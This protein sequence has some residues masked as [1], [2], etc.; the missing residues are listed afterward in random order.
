MV[1]SVGTLMSEVGAG[2]TQ[3]EGIVSFEILARGVTS[4]NMNAYRLARGFKWSDAPSTTLLG[5]ESS[6]LTCEEDAAWNAEI[7]AMLAS[8]DDITVILTVDA[9]ESTVWTI[10]GAIKINADVGV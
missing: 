6:S 3:C 4:G 9:S 5:T 8:D 10:F 2:I 1:S 7:S